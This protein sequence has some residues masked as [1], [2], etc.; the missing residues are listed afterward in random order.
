MQAW[1]SLRVKLM[2]SLSDCMGLLLC[3]IVGVSMQSCRGPL[4]V[5]L[6]L[7]SLATPVLAQSV[8]AQGSFVSGPE[9]VVCTQ[10]AWAPYPADMVLGVGT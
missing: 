9:A 6:F 4:Y 7:Q 2:A 5:F 8:C 1:E 3:C 10:V